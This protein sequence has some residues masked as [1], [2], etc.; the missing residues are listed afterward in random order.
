MKLVNFREDDL[1]AKSGALPAI[2]KAVASDA[3]YCLDVE[4]IRPCNL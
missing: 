1:H 4:T 2:Q 3:R